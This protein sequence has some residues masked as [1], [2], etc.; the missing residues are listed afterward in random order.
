MHK[1]HEN[2]SYRKKIIVLS[3]LE[4]NSHG[5]IVCIIILRD[6]N[7]LVTSQILRDTGPLFKQ[8]YTEYLSYAYQW[9]VYMSNL[10]NL[11][12]DTR[13]PEFALQNHSQHQYI[14]PLKKV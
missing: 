13:R 6:A 8:K 5:S 14:F 11:R 10:N 7:K 2:T 4:L 9:E 3:Q 1:L 12:L